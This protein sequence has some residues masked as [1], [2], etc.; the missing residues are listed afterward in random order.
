M[1]AVDPNI[2]MSPG[3]GL[4]SPIYGRHKF[5]SAQ[6]TGYEHLAPD[7]GA[8]QAAGD[9]LDAPDNLIKQNYYVL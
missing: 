4:S 5:F 3:G 6:K 2:V 8:E 7:A 1:K 9:I